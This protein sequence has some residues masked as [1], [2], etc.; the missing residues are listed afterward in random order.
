MD[1]LEY[2]A[3][4]TRNFG[5][6]DAILLQYLL[7]HFIRRW[8]IG[9]RRLI[10]VNTLFSA[11]TLVHGSCGPAQDIVVDQQQR[12]QQA[13]TPGRCFP[14][15]WM[16]M[17]HKSERHIELSSDTCFSLAYRSSHHELGRVQPHH[18]SRIRSE[19]VDSQSCNIQCPD[20]GVDEDCPVSKS[21]LPP[22]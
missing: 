14:R 15:L 17:W 22:E 1:T 8:R 4:P 5:S 11:I 18:T 13:L 10:M 3:A 21:E 7:R 2:N 9:Y 16:C 6:T 20:M 12:R 19:I